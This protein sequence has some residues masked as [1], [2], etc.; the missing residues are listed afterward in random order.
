MQT[1]L[2]ELAKYRLTKAKECLL[3]SQDAFGKDCLTKPL[4]IPITRCFM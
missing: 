1:K 4:I 2:L 3:D